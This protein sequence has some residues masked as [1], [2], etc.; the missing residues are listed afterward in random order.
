MALPQNNEK[1][2]HE[3][4]LSRT[5]EKIE[6]EEYRRRRLHQKPARSIE[7]AHAPSGTGMTSIRNGDEEQEKTHAHCHPGEYKKQRVEELQFAHRVNQKN[8]SPSACEILITAQN[9]DSG[10]DFYSISEIFQNPQM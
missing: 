3:L 6:K 10:R 5:H 1:K 7:D 4:H 2:R 8:A 9:G